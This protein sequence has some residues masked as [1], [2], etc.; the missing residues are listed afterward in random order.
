MIEAEIRKLARSDYWQTL[1]RAS[2]ELSGISLFSNTTDFSDI[3]VIF[4]YWLG[5][6]DMLYGDM[7]SKEFPM[8]DEQVIDDDDR[9]DAFLYYRHREKQKEIFQQKKE[10]NK[11]KHH[12]KNIQ[13]QEIFKGVPKKK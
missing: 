12:G 5:V 2:K 11:R 3:Q 1:Y 9:T 13:S 6:Y 7:A 10:A 8:L 4:L